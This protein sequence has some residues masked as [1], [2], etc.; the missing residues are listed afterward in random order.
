MWELSL[1]ISPT[2]PL[3]AVLANILIMKFAYT[4]KD[5]MA[6]FQAGVEMVTCSC[7]RAIRAM[8]QKELVL[9]LMTPRMIQLSPYS[10]HC[11]ARIVVR[12]PIVK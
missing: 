8:I 7:H 11:Q 1:M 6:A 9:R 5:Q 3:L 2:T 4:R 12:A 10:V